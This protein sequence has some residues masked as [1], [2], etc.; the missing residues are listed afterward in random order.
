MHAFSMK[1]K[2]SK[3]LLG[4]ES[5]RMQHLPVEKLSNNSEIANSFFV[6]ACERETS[7]IFLKT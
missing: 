6:L 3:H 1:R 5:Q 2:T 4:L 7:N